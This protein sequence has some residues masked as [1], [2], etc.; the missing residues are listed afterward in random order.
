[1]KALLKFWVVALMLF[2]NSTAFA[3]SSYPATL[4]DGNLVLIDGG[5]G[6]GK[7]ADRRSI[8][9]NL[10]SPP[11]YQ[12]SIDI[13]PVMF[14]DEYWREHGTYIGGPYRISGAFSMIFRYDWNAK[15][16]SYQRDDNWTV[17]DI[18]RSYSHADGNPL[19]PN[20][21]EVAFVSAYNMKFFGDETGYGNYRV[22][23]ESL[24][25]ALGT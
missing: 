21:A 20:A 24:Y 1:M 5:M 6:V 23:D 19:I 17:W 16:I 15:I 9:V 3:E 10:Y 13:V 7:Y 2:V 12:I 25:D 8:E 11:L 14:S 4:E 18:Y 22:I